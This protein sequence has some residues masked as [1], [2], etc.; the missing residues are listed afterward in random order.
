M[1]LTASIPSKIKK[2][3]SVRQLSY[4][5]FPTR[6]LNCALLGGPSFL[7]RIW[8]TSLTNLQA[9]GGGLFCM[10]KRKA[11]KDEVPAKLETEKEFITVST[12]SRT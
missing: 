8:N 2:Q 12:R 1:P 4:H 6:P 7:S 3:I 10:G 11:H 5:N 9:A